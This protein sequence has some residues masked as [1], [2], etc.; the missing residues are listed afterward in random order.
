MKTGTRATLLRPGVTGIVLAG[1]RSSRFGSNK[2]EA[3]ID[4]VRVI[5][6]TVAALAN[7]VDDVI[8]AGTSPGAGP[9]EALVVADPQP[10]GGPL[11]GL[12]SGLTAASRAVALVVGGDMPLLEPALLRAMVDRLASY[13][14]VASVVLGDGAE[15]LPLPMAIR[16]EAAVAAIGEALSGSDRSL[17]ALLARLPSATIPEVEWRVLD[18][19]GDTLLDIDRPADLELARARRARQPRA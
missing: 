17:R 13:P 9:V 3:L 8:V 2:L 6:R 14:T 11:V 7:V 4:G 5:D 12:R 18:P 16:V 1:G 19:D 10:S 15:V